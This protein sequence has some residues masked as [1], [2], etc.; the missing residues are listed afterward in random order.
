MR[1]FLSIWLTDWPLDR[2]VRTKRPCTEPSD[3]P[4]ESPF[5]LTER[6]T[7]GIWI[8]AA[9]TA[10]EALGVTPGLRLADARARAPQLVTEEIDR[11]ADAAALERLARWMTRWSPMAALDG[12]DGALLDVT[13]CAHLWGGESGL[14][15]DVSARLDRAG[16]RHRLGLACT[17]GAAWALAHTAP[18]QITRLEGDGAS[19]A[20]GLADLPVAAL[21][22]SEDTHTLLRR[23]GLT[24][25]GQ[26]GGIARIALARRFQSAE[27]ADR[28]LLRLDQAMGRI[29]EPL[30]PLEETAEHIARLPC[31]E[32]LLDRRGVEAG[33]QRLAT[34]LAIGLEAAG[35]G[36]RSFRLSVYRTDGTRTTREAA[37]ARPTRDPAHMVR[38]LAE[39]LD[40]LDPG[41]GI[42]LMRLE[43]DGLAPMESAPRPLPGRLG[44]EHTDLGA[45]A[46]LA[47]RMAARL[48]AETVTVAA[49]Q[50][51]HH[52]EWAEQAR[53]F[54]GALPDWHAAS[55]APG[56][57][58]PRPLSLFDRPEPLEVLAEIPDGPPV[59]FTWRQIARAV[60]RA[61]GPERIGPEWWRARPGETLRARDYYRVEDTEGRRYWLYREGLYDDGQAALPRW[62]LHG[63]FA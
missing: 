42:D 13:G 45:L 24:R 14:M 12:R 49:P 23:F 11:A 48:G 36:A 16:I 30:H 17:P 26:L 10:A 55:P 25:I 39:R 19:L 50:E 31:P 18:G 33:L 21:R 6:G 44:S 2:R 51:S 9:D 61:E 28:V 34:D 62:Y 15:A 35:R 59:R 1:R 5:A 47:D 8:A 57:D 20:G 29:A 7:A 60:A 54:A 27:A 40:G 52:P 4:D 46:A 58:G 56:R 3:T 37:A 41:F 63:L 22:L 38:L 53:P 32:P 43:A